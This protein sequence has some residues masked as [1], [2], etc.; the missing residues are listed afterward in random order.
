MPNIDAQGNIHAANGRFDGRVLTDAEDG[1]V[2]RPLDD[3]KA[4]RLRETLA[5]TTNIRDAAGTAAT[6]IS[7]ALTKDTL[8]RLFPSAAKVYF[9]R[10]DLDDSG[11]RVNAILDADGNELY[12]HAAHWQQVSEVNVSVAA[13]DD[14]Y[15][16]YDLADEFLAEH[17]GDDEMYQLLNL[18]TADHFMEPTIAEVINLEHLPWGVQDQLLRDTAFELGESITVTGKGEFDYYLDEQDEDGGIGTDEHTYDTLTEIYGSRDAA[19]TALISTKAMTRF[20]DDIHDFI[21]DR[22][23]QAMTAAISEA[24]GGPKNED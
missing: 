13:L 8:Q 9:Q 3:R 22:K 7:V 2:T 4:T 17:E 24:L 21:L 14:R 1:V 19:L 23:R 12:D 5:Y 20:E 10:A 16:D 11:W 18:T 6:R 15:F